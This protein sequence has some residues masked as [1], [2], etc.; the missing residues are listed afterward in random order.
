MMGLGKGGSGFKVWPFLVFMLNFRGVYQM[1]MGLEY[2]PMIWNY[3]PP[4]IPVTTRDYSIF[5]MESR[6]KPSFVTVTTVK[7]YNKKL[8][9]CCQTLAAFL[10]GTG[11]VRNFFRAETL[12]AHF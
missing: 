11:A 10:M 7:P 2:V 9:H 5:S 1:R 4:R 12:G 8:C 6:T 3:P